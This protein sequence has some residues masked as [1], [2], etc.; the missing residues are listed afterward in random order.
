MLYAKCRETFRLRT[1]FYPEWLLVGTG[2]PPA[3]GQA[4]VIAEEQIEAVLPVEAVTVRPDDT[5]LRLP[6]A[7]LLP[8]LINHHAHLVLPGDN[9]PFVPWIDT[10]TDAALAL[11]AAHNAAV[12]L[13][14]GVTTVRD[15]GGRGTTV[16][17]LRQAQA[18]GLEGGARVISCGWPLTITGGHTRHFG[19]EVD[20]IDGIVRM[21]RQII[22][23][24]ADFVKVM[25]SGGGTPGSLPQYPSF[26]A[27][28]LRVVVE[29]A[30][31]LGRKVAAHCI[32]TESIV[33][34]VEAGVDLIE[35]AMFVEPD[36]TLHYNPRVG[37]ILARSSIPITPTL[38]V[39][40]AM[41]EA[42]PDGPEREFWQRRSEA[43]RDVMRELHHLGVPLLAGSDAGWRATAFDTFWQELDEL[44]LCGLSSA[45]AVHAATGAVSA[46]LGESERY[47][48]IR[49]GQRADLVVIEGSLASDI[50]QLSHVTLVMLGGIA[51]RVTRSID[52]KGLNALA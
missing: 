27:A 50:R 4:V 36:M 9:T 29:T 15:C 13:H 19:G 52:N 42:L 7:T 30:H 1:I 49:A 3:T 44:V 24:G 51:V 31:E 40:R 38:Q 16:L 48:T 6:G 17:D 12:S 8:G 34:A 47:G 20:G 39:N 41:I 26:S 37:E 2:A 22:G 45:Q 43:Q 14:A 46:A 35:H 32:A 11:R 5:V 18:E 33:R 21:V 28:E 23:L 25:V 10:Q